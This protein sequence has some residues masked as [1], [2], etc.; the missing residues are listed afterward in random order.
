MR[1]GRLTSSPPGQATPPDAPRAPSADAGSYGLRSAMRESLRGYRRQAAPYQRFLYWLAVGFLLSA[2]VHGVAFLLGGRAWDGPTSWRKPMLFSF[3]FAAV[4]ASVAWVMTFLPKRA[5]LGWTLTLVFA[6]A[7]VGETAL[8]AMQ[9]WRATASHFNDRTPFDAAVFAAMGF[10]IV[11]VAAVIVVLAIWSF[12]SLRAP[13]SLAWAIRLGLI[14]VIAGQAI[15]GII[16]G[17]GLRQQEAGPVSSPVQFGETGVMNVPHA[18]AIHALQVLP[19]L[20]WLLLFSRW[21][22]RRRTALVLCAAAGYATII[23][24]SV[25]L[26]ASGR[27][28]LDVAGGTGP[29]MVAGVLL[30]A[31]AYL[32]GIAGLTK[33]RSSAELA[34]EGRVPEQPRRRMIR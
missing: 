33:T 10:L 31:A 1:R 20:G 28:P 18:L 17:E 22:E 5:K 27:S 11:G 26:A 30:V 21:D 32:V 9:A 24:A 7:S 3:S 16:L 6:G 29:M 25:A 14:L 8:I 4:S 13:T 19:V 23:A 2:A 15:G 34:G 12:A